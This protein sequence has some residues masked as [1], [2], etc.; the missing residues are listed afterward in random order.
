MKE[1]MKTHGWGGGDR[2]GGNTEGEGIKREKKES[3]KLKE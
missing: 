1:R 2:Y 3:R